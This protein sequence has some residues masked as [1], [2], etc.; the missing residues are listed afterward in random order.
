MVAARFFRNGAVLGY[1]SAGAGP[2][3]ARN[4]LC[5]LTVLTP[6][7]ADDAIDVRVLLLTNGAYVQDTDAAFWGYRVT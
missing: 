4:T 6:L 5:N 2:P 7:T 3:V 1:G